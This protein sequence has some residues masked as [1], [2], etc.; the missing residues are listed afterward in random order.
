MDELR[1]AEE[2]IRDE[3]LR[4]TVYKCPAGKWTIGVGRNL[5][6]RGISEEEAR[7]LLMN[8]IA[9]F[10]HGLRR[11]L[12]WLEAAPQPMQDV[13]ANMAFNMG[14]AGLLAF[15]R[16]LAHIQAGRYD[17][18]ADE[19]LRSRWAQQV[20]GRAERLAA[21]LRSLSATA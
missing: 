13:L 4:L 15:R 7:L 8:D 18:A 2:L 11:A 17:Q 21:V 6:D 14:L 9:F 1:L 19:M 16:T 12:P 3:G 10:R 5:E 20:G